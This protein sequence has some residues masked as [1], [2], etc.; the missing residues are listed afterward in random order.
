MKVKQAEAEISFDVT[1]PR[2]SGEGSVVVLNAR[3]LKDA[4][5]V[6]HG[7]KVELQLGTNLDPVLVTDGDTEVIIMPTRY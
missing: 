2:L 3:Y 7:D 5:S 1:A 4:M 6:L